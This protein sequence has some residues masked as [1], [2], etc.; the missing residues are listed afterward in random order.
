MHES[1]RRRRVCC[2]LQSFLKTCIGFP[3]RPCPQ[4]TCCMLSSTDKHR[5]RSSLTFHG[6]LLSASK[7]DAKGHSQQEGGRSRFC[8][9]GLLAKVAQLLAAIALGALLSN[10]RLPQQ[11]RSAE[12]R[13]SWAVSA[14][15]QAGDSRCRSTRSPGTQT[16]ISS[17]F[18][19]SRA[20]LAQ[21][22][23]VSTL[24]AAS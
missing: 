3:R 22:N 19:S 16:T 18:L 9:L 4:P 15:K 6:L 12:V 5:W 10:L 24:W 11:I 14:W 7:P 21:C 20:A 8:S 17:L 13:R 23:M 2:L 1:E